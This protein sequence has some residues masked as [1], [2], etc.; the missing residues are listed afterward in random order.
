VIISSGLLFNYL[1]FAI[2]TQLNAF[3]YLDM[4]GTAFVSFLLGP[5][6]GAITGLLSNSFVNWALSTDPTPELS[7]FPWSL[8]NMAGGI[9]WGWLA[10]RA[11]FRKYLASS[12]NSWHDDIAFLFNFGV[13][14]AGIMSIVGT[15]IEG[16]VPADNLLPVD[17][18]FAA[19][20]ASVF[21]PW[22]NSLSELLRPTLGQPLAMTLV[23]HVPDYLSTWFRYMPDK[24]LSVGFALA[25]LRY[26]FPLFERELILGNNRHEL[27]NQWI[28]PAVLSI[29]YFP[30]FVQLYHVELYNTQ[31]TSGWLWCVP[32]VIALYGIYDCLRH[33]TCIDR[34]VSDRSVRLQNYT[35]PSGSSATIAGASSF[36]HRMI[37]IA[38]VG[39]AIFVAGIKC[40]VLLGIEVNFYRNTFHFLCLVYGSL[41]GIYLARVSITQNVALCM[42]AQ[43]RGGGPK[44]DGVPEAAEEGASTQ[45]DLGRR[46]N[47]VVPLSRE[48]KRS[49]V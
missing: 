39:S 45:P 8:V 22:G 41:L 15:I 35:L 25:A 17:R 26:G 27:N 19:A 4:I 36:F 33:R 49:S 34:I 43:T 38:I 5:W 6:W 32:M 18:Q 30:S 9:F 21:R 23:E 20:I 48:V 37:Y 2:A 42:Q 28:G 29:S 44:T 12:D 7:I 40:L 1:G 31:S 16:A 46:D 47:V 3:V 24:I 14:G 11:S 13:V 10:Q